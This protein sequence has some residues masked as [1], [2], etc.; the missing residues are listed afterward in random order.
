MARSLVIKAAKISGSGP[1]GADAPGAAAEAKRT[2]RLGDRV[3]VSL[4]QDPAMRIDV[5]HP[6]NVPDEPSGLPQGLRSKKHAARLA[7]DIPSTPNHAPQQVDSPNRPAFPEWP[8]VNS[9]LPSGPMIS[10]RQ[11]TTV[12]EPFSADSRISVW[13]FRQSGYRRSWAKRNLVYFP[14]ANDSRRLKLPAMPRFVWFRTTWMRGSF[15]AAISGV[16]SVEQLSPMISSKS[17]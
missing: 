7:D 15:Y 1:G 14:F 13:I 3:G 5:E 6:R 17:S 10:R 16:P 9:R 12:T 2:Q 8:H 11:K 4:D